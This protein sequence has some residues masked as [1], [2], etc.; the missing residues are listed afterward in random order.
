MRTI[1]YWIT[2]NNI[3]GN[4]F[5]VVA[6]RNRVQSINKRCHCT[7]VVNKNTCF[8]LKLNEHL[9]PPIIMVAQDE[10]VVVVS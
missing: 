9:I 8:G 1:A 6:F 10:V 5:L 3:K 4:E 7:H 2:S